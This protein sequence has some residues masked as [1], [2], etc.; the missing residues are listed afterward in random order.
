MAIGLSYAGVSCRG[1]WLSSARICIH[2]VYAPALRARAR[3]RERDAAVQ[4]TYIPRAH[5]VPLRGALGL[6]VHQLSTCQSETPT[7]VFRYDKSSAG[8]GAQN[9]GERRARLC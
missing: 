1:V 9:G 4:S 8:A 2:I 6:A 7:I 5:L 3:V